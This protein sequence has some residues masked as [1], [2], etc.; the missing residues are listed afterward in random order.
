MLIYRRTSLLE[1]STQTLVNTVNCVGVMGKG[2]AKEFKDRD[3]KMFEAYKKICAEKKLEPGKLW[4]WR[5]SPSWIL[6]FPTKK[7]WKNSSKIEWI[8]AGL[9]KFVASYEAQG[10][11][12]ISFPRL[13]CGNGGLDWEEVR[14]LM[15]HYLSDLPMSVYVHDYT[16]DIGL[17]EHLDFLVGEIKTSWKNDF[18]FPG[19]LRALQKVADVTG[20]HV[21]FGPDGSEFTFSFDADQTL[22]IDTG[23]AHWVYE[24]DDLRGVWIGLM[25][26]LLTMDKAGW[27]DSRGASSLIALMRLLPS[28]RTVE[29]QRKGENAPELA[30]EWAPDTLG[31]SGVRSQST[32]T[33]FSWH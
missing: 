15:E 31:L 4:L 12:E 10:I 14:P 8:E 5:G 24:K 32:Q 27:V 17:P 20:S 11:T 2:I 30:V 21:N 18:S 25:N 26:G 9:Q 13:G 23:L 19:F 33:E 22:S 28:V 3:L 29:I 7:H 16:V 6:N 1:A